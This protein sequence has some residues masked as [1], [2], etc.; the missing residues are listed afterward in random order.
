[1]VASED[2]TLTGELPPGPFTPAPA[3]RDGD[4]L[5]V[6][7]YRFD[8]VVAREVTFTMDEVMY[9]ISG[10]EFD[11]CVFRQD[12]RVTKANRQQYLFSHGHGLLG[13]ARRSVYRNCTFDRI[14]FGGRGGGY[15][16]GG[17]RFEGCTFNRCDFREFD[18]FEADIVDGV[19]VGTVKSAKFC[20]P[21][22]PAVRG[23]RSNV[24]SGNDLSRAT[25]RNV[26]FR[27][28]IDLRTCRL[29]DGPEYLRIDDFPE[30]AHRALGVIAGWPDEERDDVETTLRIALEFS[31]PVFFKRRDTTI[32]MKNMA[33]LQSLLEDG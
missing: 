8:G 21:D 15:R 4:D 10:S 2:T 16:P 28:G 6:P 26:E 5:H 20:G 24:F 3:V 27:H 22:A 19:F 12:P 25:L 33:R 1:M 30:K 13:H 17:V 14:D 29:P 18:A 23:M 7:L 32:Y 31:G 11:N 9:M